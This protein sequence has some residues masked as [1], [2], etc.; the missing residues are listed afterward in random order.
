[1]KSVKIIKVIDGD[2]VVIQDEHQSYSG[3][4]INI[5]AP[6]KNQYY[7]KECKEWLQEV[8][9]GKTVL[10]TFHGKDKYGRN[11]IHWNEGE[12][13]IDELL[14]SIGHAWE[15]TKYCK[16]KSL[17]ILQNEAISINIGIWNDSS[18]VPPWIWRK[19]TNKTRNKTAA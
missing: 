19:L 14:I 11:L 18:P 13:G 2:T 4:I 9:L 12:V 5:D 16:N 6:E 8:C 10:A 7:W 17:P 15:Y 3:R 1:M